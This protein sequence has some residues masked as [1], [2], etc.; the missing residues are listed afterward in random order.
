M[1]PVSLGVVLNFHRSSAVLVVLKES[2]QCQ[3][4]RGRTGQ[5]P[6]L[7]PP[8]PAPFKPV[9]LDFYLVCCR[10]TSN[11]T[12]LF[13]FGHSEISFEEMNMKPTKNCKWVK[14]VKRLK[15]IKIV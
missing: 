8:I 13:Y 11:G 9:C 3:V 10:E 6:A 15:K 12:T 5:A 2:E 14:G 7:T 4:G 1:I